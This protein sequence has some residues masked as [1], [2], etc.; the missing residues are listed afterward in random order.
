[1]LRKAAE[2]SIESSTPEELLRFMEDEDRA[3]PNRSR[4]E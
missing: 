2:R 1:L 3:M 4:L